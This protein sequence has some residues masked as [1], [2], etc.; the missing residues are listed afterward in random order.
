LNCSQTLLVHPRVTLVSECLHN[1]F[2]LIFHSTLWCVIES[3][4][5]CPRD[6]VFVCMSNKNQCPP[7]NIFNI[8]SIL[9]LIS[10][11]FRYIIWHGVLPTSMSNIYLSYS[12]HIECSM[13]MCASLKCFVLLMFFNA[14]CIM[15]MLIIS[16]Q[17]VYLSP[18]VMHI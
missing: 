7:V 12:K 9:I 10:F 8:D 18:N 14:Q 1:F 11:A 16:S 4:S 3:E 5:M 13:C 15:R 6:K 2:F 17:L